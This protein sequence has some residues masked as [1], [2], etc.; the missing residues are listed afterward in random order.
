MATVGKLTYDPDGTPVSLTLDAQVERTATEREVSRPRQTMRSGRNAQTFALTADEMPTGD[1]VL[2][3]SSI[4]RVVFQAWIES[5]LKSGTTLR[6]FPDSTV[7]GTYSD[8]VLRG[9]RLEVRYENFLHGWYR[10]SLPVYVT[11]EATA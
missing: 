11:A 9:K 5:G 10:L 8:V 6:V 1:L 4:D 3:L 2:V 7:A